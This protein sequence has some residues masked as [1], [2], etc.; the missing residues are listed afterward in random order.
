MIFPAEH[1]RAVSS[2]GSGNA[3]SHAHGVEIPDPAFPPS[4][5]GGNAH[6]VGLNLRFAIC[7]LRGRNAD[8]LPA[9]SPTVSR[10]L[11]VNP[12]LLG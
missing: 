9:V 7:D 5:S 4:H 1:R 2:A 11:R 8:S 3:G 12:L 6:R 10:L